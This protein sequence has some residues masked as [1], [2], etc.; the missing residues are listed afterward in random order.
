[1]NLPQSKCYSVLIR[2][3]NSSNTLP[4]TL[5]SLEN[6]TVRPSQYVFVDSG[7]SDATLDLIPQESVIHKI[8]EREFNYSAALNKGLLDIKSKYVLIISSH[9]SINRSD[10]VHFAL[11]LLCAD[12]KIGAVYFS[13]ENVGDLRYELVDKSNFTGFNGLWNTCSLI[14]MEILRIRGFRE[15]VFA[16]EDQEWASWLFCYEAK[17]TARILGGEVVNNNPRKTSLRK[18]SNDYVSVA[19]FSNRKLMGVRNICSLAFNVV[20]PRGGFRIKNRFL[21]LLLLCRIISC[22]FVKPK[23]KSRYY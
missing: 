18:F 10:A 12:E 21:F 3:F 14:R 19:Y 6:Q 23:A 16:A 2:T 7:S 9:T 8:P 22:Y 1:M 17:K 20:R 5:K 4:L 15:D 11:N 13:E